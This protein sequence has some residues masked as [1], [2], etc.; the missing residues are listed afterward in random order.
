MCVE[1]TK[2]HFRKQKEFGCEKILSNRLATTSSSSAERKKKKGRGLQGSKRR[3]YNIA[4]VSAVRSACPVHNVFFLQS[5][6]WYSR[7]MY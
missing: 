2:R 4:A 6:T 3:K 1:I 7:A 5:L